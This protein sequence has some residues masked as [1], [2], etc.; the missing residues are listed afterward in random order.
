M[1]QGRFLLGFVLAVAA[2][3][4]YLSERNRLEKHVRWG[5]DSTVW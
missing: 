5:G 3:Q 2:V 1:I 4:A